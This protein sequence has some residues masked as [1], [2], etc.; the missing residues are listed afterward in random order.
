MLYSEML[1]A[2][3]QLQ[4]WKARKPDRAPQVPAEFPGHRASLIRFVFRLETLQNT[5]GRHL[6]ALSF[7]DLRTLVCS[8]ASDRTT[9]YILPKLTCVERE[10]DALG[11]SPLVGELRDLQAGSR[12]MD[13]RV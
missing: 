3:E 9:P 13:R 10:L 12:Q 1:A 7:G 5:L 11:A 8:L 6:D 2:A 4:R